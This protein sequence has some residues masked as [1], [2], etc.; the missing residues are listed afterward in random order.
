[1]IWAKA[2]SGRAGW[3]SG[4]GASM[5][6]IVSGVVAGDVVVSAATFLI[7]AEATSTRPLQPSQLRLRAG[8]DRDRPDHRLVYQKRTAGAVC[9]RLHRGGLWSLHLCRSDAIP[10]LS[11][12]G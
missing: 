5:I 1:M 7:D 2:G 11:D 6:E 3:S 8:G 4:A 10:D 9:D 12:V